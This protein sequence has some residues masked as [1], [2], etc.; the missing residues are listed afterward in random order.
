MKISILRENEITPAR[1]T[2]IN[3]KGSEHYNMLFGDK[4][5]G[6]W[7][8]R[9][10][11]DD[12]IVKSMEDAEI[13]L[14]DGDYSLIPVSNARGQQQDAVGNLMYFISKSR[15]RKLKGVVLGI[16]FTY[17]GDYNIL[18]DSA[19]LIGTGKTI[20]L[21]V[22]YDVPVLVFT[23]TSNTV[24]SYTTPFGDKVTTFI[25]YNLDRD[26]LVVKSTIIKQKD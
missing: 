6:A 23:K 13:D 8:Y 11:V 16:N 7:Q 15:Q 10:G 26:E 18:L 12:N 14:V 5:Y 25:R 9:V 2:K 1:A 21:N 3:V 17:N 20:N 22:T 4:C 24:L 19:L